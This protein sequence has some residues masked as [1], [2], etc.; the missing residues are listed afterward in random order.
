MYDTVDEFVIDIS[1]MRHSYV[2]SQLRPINEYFKKCEKKKPTKYH[3]DIK[4]EKNKPLARS[5]NITNGT[6]GKQQYFWQ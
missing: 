1:G 3:L 5:S 4:K 6:Y 2:T